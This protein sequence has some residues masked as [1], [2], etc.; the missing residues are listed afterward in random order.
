M[1]P[2]RSCVIE[3]NSVAETVMSAEFP[4]HVA[5]PPAESAGELAATSNAAQVGH[6]FAIARFWPALIGGSAVLA[7]IVWLTFVRPGS[8]LHAVLNGRRFSPEEQKQ[9]ERTL[10]ESGVSHCRFVDEKLLVPQDALAASNKALSAALAN[11]DASVASRATAGSWLDQFATSRRQKNVDETAKAAQLGKLLAQL[12]GVES[13][14]VVWDEEPRVG[15]RQAPR[16]RATVFLQPEPGATIGFDIV[17][18]VRAAVSGSRAHLAAEDVLV[19]DLQRRVTYGPETDSAALT[20]ELQRTELIAACRSRV[21]SALSD[22][23]G[24]NVTVFLDAARSPAARP[25]PSAGHSRIAGVSGPNLRLEVS[26]IPVEGSA[27]PVP[28]ATVEY[29]QLGVSVAVPAACLTERSGALEQSRTVRH[30]LRHADQG[31]EESRLSVENEI[32]QRVARAVSGLPVTLNLSQLNIAW[33]QPDTAPSRSLAVN[34]G[35]HSEFA[36]WVAIKNVATAFVIRKP[37]TAGAI[38]LALSGVSWLFVLRR[39][40]SRRKPRGAKSKQTA[41]AAASLEFLP[42][43]D[44]A[45]WAPLI[46]HEPTPIIAGLLRRLAP[47][48]VAQVIAHLSAVQQRDVLELAPSVEFGPLEFE[49][50]QRRIRA[51]VQQAAPELPSA[52]APRRAVASAPMVRRSP[53]SPAQPT[54]FDDLLGAD[55]GSLRMLTSRV[56][57]ETWS[58]ALMGASPKLQRRLSRL[59]LAIDCTRQGTDRRPLRLREIESAQRMIIDEWQ[60]LQTHR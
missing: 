51:A 19:M 1:R 47:D 54:A 55:E 2:G 7:A 18:A 41:H 40:S 37:V 22:F 49:S 36:N 34:A 14:E 32:R 13:A 5:S 15:R 53:P 52:E 60:A 17:Q 50:L 58:A 39:R 20:A 29:P 12:A 48:D 46:A 9:A 56:P 3:S 59:N 10:R 31:N 16:V 33:N 27:A 11:A 25:V 28:A 30:R 23:N 8:D 26:R 45:I 21:E 57:P 43:I 44:S 6:R 35:P 4:Q 42:A 38:L 24:A